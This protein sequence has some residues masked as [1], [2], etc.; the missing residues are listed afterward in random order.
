M[1]EENKVIET[2]NDGLLS[3]PSSG[4][5]ASNVLLDPIKPGRDWK[6]WF[7]FGTAILAIFIGIMAPYGAGWGLWNWQSGLKFLSW[8]FFV[9][10]GSIL[11]G[12]LFSWRARRAG[13]P[14]NRILR[15]GGIFIASGYAFWI[16]TYIVA[17]LGNPL[18][19]V[20]T[21]LADPPRFSSIEMRKD[22]F[23]QIP[24]ADDTAMR[25]MNPEQRWAVIHQKK[26]GDIRSVRVSL[27][28]NEV[29]TK[30]ERLA[31]ARGWTIAL[32]L[33][34]EGRFEATAESAMFKFKDDVVLR[35]RSAD[36]SGGSIVD[37]RSISRVGQSDLGVN[38]K[39]VRSFLADLS[40][41]LTAA[42]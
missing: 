15:W 14:G 23:D 21:D 5:T 10:I 42:P 16:G 24:G 4:T 20:S 11:F 22:N 12:L 8:S 35:V 26:Y 34:A 13:A 19:D 27:P 32:S 1:I 28:V 38:A 37:M 18:H 7:V 2:H 25:G 30:A 40:G 39:R 29:I 9:A 41:T 33:P 17:A 31:K 6:A 3:S 36:N